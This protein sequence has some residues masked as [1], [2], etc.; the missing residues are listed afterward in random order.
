MYSCSLARGATRGAGLIRPATSPYRTKSIP[1]TLDSRTS[2][3]CRDRVRSSQWRTQRL[4][5]I[6]S[7][8]GSRTYA[9][10]T[11]ARPLSLPSWPA[12][13]KI[14]PRFGVT[15]QAST[16]T[17]PASIPP[18][19]RA[20]SSSSDSL[21][22]P[23]TPRRRSR[24]RFLYYLAA[25]LAITGIC[26]ETIPPARHLL[27]ASIRCLRLVK[28]VGLSVLDYKYTF[29]D[30]YPADKYSEQERKQLARTDRHAC[31]AR[32]SERLFQALKSNAGIY[33]KLGQ[34]IASIQALPIECVI[35]NR[36]LA[37]D[38]STLIFFLAS[39]GHMHLQMDN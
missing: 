29:L 15:R 13:S 32:S 30:W 31:H 24:L 38:R 1:L 17:G 39:G 25:F 14:A 6:S 20:S 34:H 36:S 5:N 8:A 11:C 4:L 3:A 33:V 19:G 7:V 9:S 26:Y 10:W 28:A 37:G 12:P 22:P 2:S 35:E 27:I 18:T 16:G 21:K 23:R